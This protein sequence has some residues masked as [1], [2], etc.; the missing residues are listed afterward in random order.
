MKIKEKGLTGKAKINRKSSN[1]GPRSFNAFAEMRRESQ[2]KTKGGEKRKAEIWLE[3]MGTKIRVHEE[4]EG[5]I[6]AEDI[7]YVKGSAL[8]FT[9]CG[10]EI[11]WSDI[12]VVSVFPMP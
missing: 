10:G 2:Q 4:N 9:G 7:P 12:K 5:S 6:K 11:S 8:M 1:V 3:F